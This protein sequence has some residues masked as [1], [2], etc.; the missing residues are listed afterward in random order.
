MLKALFCPPIT[1]INVFLQLCHGV[2]RI[3]CVV[4]S[5]QVFYEEKSYFTY[6]VN[7]MAFHSGV[8]VL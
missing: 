5:C 6:L 3:E 2:Q 4:R 7:K 1:K 8:T